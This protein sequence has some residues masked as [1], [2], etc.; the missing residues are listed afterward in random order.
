MSRP[1]PVGEEGQPPSGP[2]DAARSGSAARAGRGAAGGS[3]G[4]RAERGARSAPEGDLSGG[5]GTSSGEDAGGAGRR[6]LTRTRQHKVGGVCGGLGRYYDMD[7]VIFR[8]PLA[9]LCVLGGLGL[10]FYGFAWLVVPMEGEREN[11]ARRMLSGRVETS[12]LAAIV[13]ALAGSG[14]ML[15]S[16]GSRTLVSSVLLAAAVAGAAHWSVHR[17]SAE[18]AGAEGVPLDPTTA[19]AVADAP[20]ETQAPPSPSYPSWWREPLTREAGAVKGT[21]YLW[22]PEGLPESAGHP[23][24]SG[25]PDSPGR[26]GPVASPPEAAPERC[27]SIGGL[28]QLLAFLTC[29]GGVVASWSQRPVGTSLAFGL[30]CALAVYGLALVV[31]AFAGRVGGGTMVMTVL[32]ALALAGA[33]ALPKDISTDWR[34]TTWSPAGASELRPRYALGSGSGELDLRK[35][36]LEK[37]ET[38]RSS[39]RVGAGTLRVLVPHDV[40][41]RLTARADLGAIRV[42]TKVETKSGGAGG[43]RVVHDDSGGLDTERRMTLVPGDLH[44]PKGEPVPDR[45][46]LHLNLDVGVGHVEVVRELPTGERSDRVEEA[47]A[48]AAARTEE[49]NRP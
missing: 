22:G 7:P 33:A 48:T 3:G 42:A 36:G 13:T 10:L 37:K 4:P 39:A 32:T 35:L 49:V 24:A 44:R 16:L 23:A 11:E 30:G 46:R 20:P 19:H 41:V 38:V 28:V 18:A 26:P 5:D 2:E 27:A 15:A 29:A 1:D 6:R 45:G 31:S 34:E 25:T 8:V 12:T 17:R 43:H 47:A 9:V 14:L 21:G 40:T